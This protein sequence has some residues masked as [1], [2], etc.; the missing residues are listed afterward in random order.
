AGYFRGTGDGDPND[1][2]HGTF[3]Q[4]LPTPRVYARFPFYNLMNNEDTFVQLRLKPHAR[5]SVRTD[6]RYLRLSSRTDLWYLG[7]GAFQSN[8][9]GFIGRPSGGNRTLGTLGDLSVD[10]NLTPT[11]VVTFYLAGVSGGGVQA[12]VYPEGGAHPGARFLYFELTQRF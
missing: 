1:D 9:F 12:F 3:F 10:Y 8:T 4:V 11:T 6:L 5:L 2:R 7:G